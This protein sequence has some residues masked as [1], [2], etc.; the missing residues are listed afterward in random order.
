[1]PH[2][3]AR[4]MG[5]AL[6]HLL[7]TNTIPLAAHIAHRRMHAL[8]QLIEVKRLALNQQST[9]KTV[10]RLQTGIYRSLDRET[11]VALIAHLTHPVWPPRQAQP[12]ARPQRLRHTQ[13]ARKDRCALQLL[14]LP[15]RG[16]KPCIVGKANEACQDV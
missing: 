16:G 13:S 3:L 7:K 9:L 11:K 2:C 8:A 1:M 4:S 15:D 5:I 6:L 10:T 14:P 12:I